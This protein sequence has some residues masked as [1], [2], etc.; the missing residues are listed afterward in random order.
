MHRSPISYRFSVHHYYFKN[1]FK[2]PYLNSLLGV[3]YTPNSY[4]KAYAK[5][6]LRRI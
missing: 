3:A 4:K 2:T 5:I 1:T 6:S